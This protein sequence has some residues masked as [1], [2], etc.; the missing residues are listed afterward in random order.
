MTTPEP[1]T[2]ALEP[3]RRHALPRQVRLLVVDG[4]D[5]G[6]TLDLGVEPVVV[7][8][9][10]ECALVLHDSG[11]SR[12]HLRVHLQP[13]GVLIHDLASRN[14]SFFQGGRFSELQ[15]G[16]GAVIQLGSSA[17]RLA[18]AS[19]SGGLPPSRAER[20]G[21]LVGRSL[22]M[23]EVFALLDRVAGTRT[24][25]LLCG[26]TG[27]GKDLCAEALHQAGPR[28]HRPYV[29]CD[30]SGLSPTLIESDLFGHLRG[31]FTGAERDRPGAF[32]DADGGTLFINE[33]GELPL[34]CQPRLLRAID[35]GQIKPVGAGRYRHVDLRVIAATHC[36]LA[37]NVKSGRFRADLYY[38][39]NVV[40]IDLPPLRSRREDIPLI[41]RELLPD[42]GYVV[43][44]ET[45]ALLIE[46]DWP[47]NVRELR[48][49]LERAISLCGPARSLT[50]EMF[51]TD[52]VAP[53]ASAVSGVAEGPIE[54]FACTKRRIVAEWERLFLATLLRR[55][56]G[57]ITRAAHEGRVD[58]VYIYR[59]MRK[60]GIAQGA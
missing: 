32:V 48:N 6:A 56:N 39:L 19:A 4:P 57:N 15:V 42:P 31:A 41:V 18:T 53:F 25:V 12:R 9:A 13:Q 30:V 16:A 14:G 21:R 38:R 35:Q 1:R 2:D 45:M 7:G 20:F 29:E 58:R 5:V 49:A 26:E 46:R 36:D 40:R 52:D 10:P 47:G 37:A 27:T 44:A 8:H 43:P 59:L 33:V 23:R 28:A 17:I 50:P 51:L 3:P 24:P 54:G 22:R 11:V 55:A 34:D 60:H